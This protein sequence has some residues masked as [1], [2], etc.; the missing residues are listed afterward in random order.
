MTGLEMR[1]LIYEGTCPQCGS[2]L[3]ERTRVKEVVTYGKCSTC[4]IHWDAWETPGN[5][6]VEA[7]SW[8]K[9]ASRQT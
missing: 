7:T 9:Q 1:K 3:Q 2:E 4:G 5:F 8:Q 6:T